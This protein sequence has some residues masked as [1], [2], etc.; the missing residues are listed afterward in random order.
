M[1]GTCSQ[2]WLRWAMGQP[3]QNGMHAALKSRHLVASWYGCI[4][5]PD[6]TWRQYGGATGC[7]WRDGWLEFGDWTGQGER[8]LMPPRY[9]LTGILLTEA[10]PLRNAA[11]SSKRPSNF[12]PIL[13]SRNQQL[14]T[15]P[16]ASLLMTQVYP[17]ID[18]S[19]QVCMYV[20]LYVCQSPAPSIISTEIAR[21]L[22]RLCALPSWH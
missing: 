22:S 15:N 13:A 7:R 6:A 18:L 2:Q 16:S 17:S 20:C 12:A 1:Q 21:L 10:M 14:H 4:G 19:V 9:C 5:Q 8:E 11:P 3:P